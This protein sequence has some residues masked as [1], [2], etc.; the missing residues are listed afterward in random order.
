VKWIIA[1]LVLIAPLSSIQADEQASEEAALRVFIDNFFTEFTQ[2]NPMLG[3][4]E[5]GADK[6]SPLALSSFVIA[7]FTRP[8]EADKRS[9][10]IA[11]VDLI[12]QLFM[13]GPNG[14]VIEDL[15]ISGDVARADINFGSVKNKIPE[16]L[17]FSFRLIKDGDTWK[18]FRFVDLRPKAPKVEKKEIKVQQATGDP[19]ATTKAYLDLI[20]D[21]YNPDNA[22]KATARLIDIS[23]AIRPLWV[24]AREARR[25]AG[26]LQAQFA[27]TQ[28]FEWR[29]LETSLNGDTADVTVELRVGN[30]LM[31]DNAMM[32][33]MLGGETPRFV[34]K[35]K[36]ESGVWKLT[37]FT[38]KPA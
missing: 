38:R 30:K 11:P 29:H 34:F 24:D 10:R 33:K 21:L 18:F 19:V 35:L 17:A 6:R 13:H 26:Q 8:S 32:L 27:Q 5:D 16:P 37:G 14:W 7:R 23:K 36:K 25:T 9:G 20:I 3:A 4:D 2:L 28:P 12:A 15:R 22:A 1:L 31:L